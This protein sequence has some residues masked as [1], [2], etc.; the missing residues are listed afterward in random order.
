MLITNHEKN[1]NLLLDNLKTLKNLIHLIQINFL[2]I[3]SIS[4][5]TN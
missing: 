1:L 4:R 3:Y 5:I 2:S